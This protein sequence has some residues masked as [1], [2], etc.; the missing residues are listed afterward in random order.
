MSEALLE[1]LL[2]K[3]KQS[4]AAITRIE[5]FFVNNENND[6]IS[7]TEFISR[8]E[9]L[10]KHFEQYCT[11]QSEIEI[12]DETQEIDRESIESKY[13]SLLA[14]YKSKTKPHTTSNTNSSDNDLNNSLAQS[15]HS[16]S[17]A[18]NKVNLP[19]LDTPKFSGKYEDWN[20]FIDLFTALIDRND[21]LSKVQ[22]FVYLKTSLDK[23]PL[24]LIN[25]LQLTDANYDIALNLLKNR[26]DNNLIIIN[27]HLKGML[28]TPPLTKGDAVQ[29]RPFITNIKQHL[30][31][32]KALDTQAETWDLI[33]IYLFSR[34]LDFQTQRAYELEKDHSVIPKLDDFLSFLEKR[35][36]GLENIAQPEIA[37]HDTRVKPRIGYQSNTNIR[38]T[39][40]SGN[41]KSNC[42]YCNLDNH[43]IY[44][45]TKFKALSFPQKR[46]FV[47]D[48]KLCYNCLGSRHSTDNCQS[49]GCRLCN[50]KHNSLLHYDSAQN[51]T[52]SSLNSHSHPQSSRENQSY[53]DIHVSPNKNENSQQISRETPNSSQ[54][55]VNTNNKTSLLTNKIHSQILLAT[56]VVR[57]QAANGNIIHARA[58]LDCASQTTFITQDLI[59]RLEAPIYS[60]NLQISGIGDTTT[61][62]TNMVDLILL[63][64]IDK[65]FKTKITCAIMDKITCCLPHVR[66]DTTE[67]NIPTNVTLAD[68]NYFT[69]SAIQLLIGADVYFD[70]LLP[71]LISLGKNLPTLQNS[72]LGWLIAGHVP[73]RNFSLKNNT[74]FSVS[75]FSNSDHTNDL[76]SKFWQLEQISDAK[77]LS[78]A[79][80]ICEKTFLSSIKTLK[81]GS[82]QVDLPLKTQNILHDLKDSFT[83]AS[84]RFYA[85]EKRFAKDE[86]LKLRYTQFIEEYVE[87]GHGKY[88]EFNANNSEHTSN[89]NFLPHQC[90]IREASES[91]KLRVVFDCS[92]KMQAGL[93]L[94]DLMYKGFTVQP[95]LF[96]I[97]LRFRTFK[98]VVIADIVKMYRAIKVNPNQC[99]LQN[100]LWRN[101]PYQELK[102]IELQT[103]TYGCNNSPYLATRTLNYIADNN[104]IEYPLAANAI[105]NQTYL[106]DILGG[107][108]TLS[109]A[110]QL[111]DQLIDM[112]GS[113]GFSLHKWKSNYESV[114]KSPTEKLLTNSIIK[115]PEHSDKI[116]GL[117]WDGKSDTFGITQPTSDCSSAVTKRQVLSCISQMFDP[118]GLISPV[119][120]IAKMLMQEIWLKKI[121]WDERL[122]DDLLKKWSSF[123]NNLSLLSECKIP[124][125]NF[126]PSQNIKEIQIH[127][128]SDASLKAY[129]AAVYIRAI[130]TDNSVTC[131]LLCSKSRITP[132]KQISIPRLEL[133]AAL[134]SSK[135]VNKICTI[136]SQN[137]NKVIMWTDSQ[138]VLCWIRLESHRLTTFVANRVA[139]IQD[140]TSSYEWKY[141]KSAHNPADCLSRGLTPFDILNHELW[142]TGPNSLH[143][144]NSNITGDEE[145]ELISIPEQKTITHLQQSTELF[146]W[147]RF[148][149]F[150]KLQR[151]FAFIL[152]F[153]HNSKNRTNKING[154][155]KVSELKRSLLLIIKLI[156]KEH[157]S[158]EINKLKSTKILTDSKLLMLNPILDDNEC[159]RVNGRLTNADINYDQKFPLILPSKNHVVKLLIKQE[160][161][162]LA[163][164][165][166]QLVLASLRQRY[167][168]LRGLREIKSIIHQ[169]ITCHK[170]K[171]KSA[172]QL[173]G[174]LPQ[175]RVT[176]S[177]P[178]LKVGIDFGGPLMVKTSRI[179][180]T[181]ITKSYIAL[182]VCMSTKAVHI[183][184]VSSLSTDAFIL[185]FKRFISRRGLAHTIYSDNGTNFQGANNQLRELYTFFK[186]EKTLDKIKDFLSTHEITWKFIPPHSPHWGGLWEANI[187]SAKYHLKRIVGNSQL[188][189]E[190]LTTV[191]AQIEAIINSRPLCPISSDPSDLSCLTPSHFLIGDVLTSYPER[192]VS[193]IPD[194]RLSF[195]KLGSK[196]RQH[197]WKRWS[198]E[199]LNRL[200]HRPKWF[201]ATENL[202]PNTIVLLKEDNVPPMCW[203]L[204]R[205]LKVLPGK[206][207]KV[208]LCEI[209][210]K[211]GTFLR[212]ISKLCPLPY[213][214]SEGIASAGGRMLETD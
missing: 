207:G 210:T 183:E 142:W 181:V 138:I 64:Q 61:Q 191:L 167:W 151:T 173:M 169:C 105:L 54:N 94:N 51:R 19:K 10:N 150:S 156:Q 67:I 28:D 117:S 114:L 140:L 201:K 89:K 41:F 32:L 205:I 196:I 152:R 88:V 22:K 100:I 143:T 197:F 60:Q 57:L 82:L 192:D 96:D 147:N 37:K 24:S 79:D 50:G 53:S 35:C 33:L 106:D 15:Q 42:I 127:A 124:R 99:H 214:N 154:P 171:A 176:A 109:E 48:K 188:T 172:M 78:P 72:R 47:N 189:F 11:L 26:Y 68:A 46:Y 30:D 125:Y 213:Y 4:K 25:N 182:F 2:K 185:A 126:V 161:F 43:D 83:I 75:L 20:S 56:A 112:L 162:R 45:C 202:K 74:H 115:S 199:Y 111:H 52:Q 118:L 120:V 190:E 200:Q 206:D 16:S 155:L 27:S 40:Y 139:I 93:S 63:S 132:L 77:V 168:P 123:S 212:P 121:Q 66:V 92:C 3:R 81:D 21:Q 97:L 12:L 194:N 76:L 170:L 39:L 116:L 160:H 209:L 110:M 135:L 158:N 131:T 187:K 141:I 145:L 175:D 90:V 36:V 129:G 163:H 9:H 87:L 84:Q 179:R 184:L 23:E 128:F 85:L 71:G 174:S 17:S 59:D 86:N 102:C 18:L 134:L 144:S 69:P 177:R 91:T 6:L 198:L 1:Q 180:K 133:S 178:F 137:I 149:T 95:E 208:R 5:K 7:L 204:A 165:G 113:S 164:A 34:K 14:K 8:E 166:P 62:T 58:L 159:L 103:L 153:I 38:S 119:T 108:E 136:L 107:A 80:K 98:Y 195:W 29:L 157:F 65:H 130:Y 31:S 55:N 186:N 211:S 13:F 148:S 73:T 44:R 101:S 203:P 146:P 193:D 122:P 49:R 104:K 70:L